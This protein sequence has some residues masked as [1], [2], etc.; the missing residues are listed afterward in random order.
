MPAA[1]WF[2]ALAMQSTEKAWKFHDILFKNQDKLGIDFF[3]KTVGD[4]GADVIK[5][6]PKEG[7]P[8]RGFMRVIGAPR[9]R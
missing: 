1:Q 4:L 5:V 8:G 6:E 2:E 3:R 9:L 7:D